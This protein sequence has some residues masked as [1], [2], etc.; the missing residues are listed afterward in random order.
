[1]KVATAIAINITPIKIYVIIYC[2]LLLNLAVI[3]G[4]SFFIAKEITTAPIIVTPHV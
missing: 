4:R 2:S 1:M 3:C